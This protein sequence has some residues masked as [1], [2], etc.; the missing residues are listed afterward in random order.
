M[1]ICGLGGAAMSEQSFFQNALANFTHEVA[2]G[3]AIRHLTDMGYTVKQISERLDFPTPFERIQ[4]QVWERL[5]ETETVLTE[6]PGSSCREKVDY[7]REYD[8]YGRAS[9]RRVVVASPKMSVI[10]WRDMEI[11]S[12]EKE[13][14][15]SHLETKIAENEEIHSY[16]SCEFGLLTRREPQR[17][18]ELLQAL[19]ECQREYVA[20]LPWEAKKVYHRL[21][22]RMREIILQLLM[23]GL[24]KGQCYF[25]KTGERLYL[26]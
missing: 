2:S 25:L 16:V 12:E 24:W 9:F 23:K 26:K 1:V 3:G 4:R 19:D 11:D 8:K 6:E 18:Q 7:V 5:L 14:I 17:F 21:N 13:K 10:Q 15:R 22:F 20:G